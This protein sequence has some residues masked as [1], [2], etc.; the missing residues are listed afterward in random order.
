MDDGIIAHE[1]QFFK[2]GYNPSPLEYKYYN[3]FYDF[4]H[5]FLAFLCH[6]YQTVYNN[7]SFS[8]NPG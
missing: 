2:R 6:P 3:D 1:N 5:Q 8:A 7:L 4:V